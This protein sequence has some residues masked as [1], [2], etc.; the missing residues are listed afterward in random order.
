MLSADRTTCQRNNL[1]DGGNTAARLVVGQQRLQVILVNRIPGTACVK[2]SFCAGR[3]DP[4]I[5]SAV[6]TRRKLLHEDAVGRGNCVATVMSA[7]LVPEDA[8]AG[9]VKPRVCGAIGISGEIRT[10]TDRCH[11]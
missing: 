9:H 4:H 6:V 2:D 1:L 11:H 7:K 3:T 5:G 8:I 10:Q